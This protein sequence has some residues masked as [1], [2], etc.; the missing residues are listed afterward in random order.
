LAFSARGRYTEQRDRSSFRFRGGHAINGKLVVRKTIASSY[1]RQVGP[2]LGLQVG[3]QVGR[4]RMK[5]DGMFT[6]Y[7]RDPVLTA[8]R[9]RDG[10]FYPM[11]SARWDEQGM[12]YSKILRNQIVVPRT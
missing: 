5:W 4:L 10:W 2:V 1:T 6:E 3:L 7:Y 9:F 12:L 11:D 8:E